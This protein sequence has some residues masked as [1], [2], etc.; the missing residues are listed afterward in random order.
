[1]KQ[2]RTF[3]SPAT[4][5][6]E[7]LALEASYAALEAKARAEK[8]AQARAVALAGWEARSAVPGHDCVQHGLVELI[9]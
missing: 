7:R 9:R 1:M 3:E 2:R 4:K 6:A 8:E 5:L